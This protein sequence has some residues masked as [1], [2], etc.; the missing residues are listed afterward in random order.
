MTSQESGHMTLRHG[1]SDRVPISP[2]TVWFLV[3]VNEPG[4]L[5]TYDFKCTDNGLK[6]LLSFLRGPQRTNLALVIAIWHG[7]YRTDAFVMDVP[8]LEKR[9]E[10]ALTDRDKARHESR[11]MKRQH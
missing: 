11:A 6:E 7:E 3:I 8:S 2:S 10:Q 1:E 4:S 9:A 5:K